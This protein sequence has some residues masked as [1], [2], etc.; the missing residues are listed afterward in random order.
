MIREK[1]KSCREMALRLF[2]SWG[3][4]GKILL[5]PIVVGGEV[6]GS[7]DDSV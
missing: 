5:V 1:A 2:L 7:S 4:Y 6:C 3:I